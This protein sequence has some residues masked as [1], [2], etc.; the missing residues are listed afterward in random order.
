MD[1]VSVNLDRK[2]RTLKFLSEEVEDKEKKPLKSYKIY[3]EKSK[4]LEKDIQTIE[5]AKVK[6]ETEIEN[7]MR[8]TDD[9][10]KIEER[11]ALQKKNLHDLKIE[12]EASKLL[13]D[14]TGLLS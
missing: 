1:E 9:I 2:E 7:L 14:L 8:N 11:L 10:N 3:E 13:Y 4:R 6:N 5:L 12:A